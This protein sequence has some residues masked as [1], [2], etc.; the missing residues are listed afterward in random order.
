M[1]VLSTGCGTTPGA[2]RRP[3]SWHESN[4]TRRT[5]S[6]VHF[7]L[8]LLHGRGRRDPRSDPVPREPHPAHSWRLPG[9][10]AG[11]G[12]DPGFRDPERLVRPR[13][14]SHQP[15]EY[16]RGVHV[17]TARRAS[18]GVAVPAGRGRRGRRRVGR[19]R[20]PGPQP[21]GE[22]AGRADRLAEPGGDVVNGSMSDS[23]GRA[24]MLV[25]FWLGIGSAAQA[26][27]IGVACAG[28]GLL[29]V[30]VLALIAWDVRKAWKRHNRG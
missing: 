22:V 30:T 13:C 17:R 19:H 29:T 26:P 21:G 24:L 3:R 11:S 5:A 25:G 15:D 6:D 18:G 2:P 9:R 12:V 10:V 20:H 27:S 1:S 14:R 8:L 28:G 7:C 23:W 16:P 4:T